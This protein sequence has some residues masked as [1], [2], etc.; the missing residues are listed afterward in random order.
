MGYA[1]S[2]NR[3]I[4]HG[5]TVKGESLMGWQNDKIHRMRY[6]PLIEWITDDHDCL[7]HLAWHTIYLWIIVSLCCSFLVFVLPK[8]LNFTLKI[9]KHASIHRR[10]RNKNTL[11]F[12]SYLLNFQSSLH[13]LEPDL[14][15]PIFSTG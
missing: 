7:C 8:C 12:E 9:T 15:I 10:S 1:R 2:F 13:Y 6:N 11:I 4:G 14:D 3:M 5:T